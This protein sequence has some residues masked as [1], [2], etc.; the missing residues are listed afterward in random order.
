M[1]IRTKLIETETK[2]KIRAEWIREAHIQNIGRDYS[3][4]VCTQ[5]DEVIQPKHKEMCMISAAGNFPR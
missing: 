3:W 1:Q 4:V 5:T 2:P